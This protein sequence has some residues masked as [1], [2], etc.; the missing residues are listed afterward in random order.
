VPAAGVGHDGQQRTP[1]AGTQGR[2][3][4]QVDVP[5]PADRLGRAVAFVEV[6]AVEEQRVDRL[7]PFQVHDPEDVPRRQ[8]VRP[9]LAGRQRDVDGGVPGI[10]IALALAKGRHDAPCVSAA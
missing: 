10:Q 1:L 5:L 3:G 8:L 2:A 9:S 6:A 4:R 7:V